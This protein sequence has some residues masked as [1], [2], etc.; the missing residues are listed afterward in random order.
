MT[1][2]KMYFFTVY[3]WIVKKNMYKNV[4]FPNKM[5]SVTYVKKDDTHFASVF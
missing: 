3:V 4:M 1:E 5:K 2:T